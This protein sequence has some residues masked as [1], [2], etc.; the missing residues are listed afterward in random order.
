MTNPIGPGTFFKTFYTHEYNSKRIFYWDWIWSSTDWLHFW[1]SR[2]LCSSR[3]RPQEKSLVD[4]LPLDQNLLK[5]VLSWTAFLNWRPLVIKCNFG[6][7]FSE[8]IKPH[9]IFH[10]ILLPAGRAQLP[11]HGPFDERLR[12]VAWN[13]SRP[14][15]GATNGRAMGRSGHFDSHFSVCFSRLNIIPSKIVDSPSVS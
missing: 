1:G 10:Q 14:Q 3:L 4:Q 15:R 5:T 6:I 11:Y 2:P 13:G 8:L 9:G 12:E 7:I